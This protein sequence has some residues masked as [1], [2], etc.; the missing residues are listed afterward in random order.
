MNRNL[1]D[2]LRE[3]FCKLKVVQTIACSSKT[4]IEDPI[5]LAYDIITEIKTSKVCFILRMIPI[6]GTYKAYDKS[7]EKLGDKIMLIIF[8]EGTEMT[9]YI[10]FKTKNNNNISRDET[11][12]FIGGVV[13][14][15]AGKT[16]VDLKNPDIIRTLRGSS[17]NKTR[18]GASKTGG[19]VNE[20]PLKEY[21]RERFRW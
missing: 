4:T 20:T 11:I 19:S 17:R 6:L 14:S 5:K 18:S 9:Y 2:L 3:D 21:P 13:K 16:S 15:Q 12:Q 1:K 7:I 10:L 8:K